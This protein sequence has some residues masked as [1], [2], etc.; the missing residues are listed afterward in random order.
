M[1]F[2]IHG[3]PMAPFAPLFELDDTALASMGATR[4]M[5]TSNPGFP[6]RVSLKDADVGEELILLNHRH[7][8]SNSPYAATHA[9]YVRKDARE[10]RPAPSEVPEVLSSRLL[11][12]RAFDAADMMQRA[13]V[14]EGDRLGDRL[15][16]ILAD[17]AIA[18]VHIHNAAPGCF[19]A[20]ATRAE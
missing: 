13:E 1:T 15:Q 14:V 11:S 5:A 12:L 20:S 3:L 6:C 8:P 7:L 19:A 10:A 18:Y 9:I 16:D 17:A 4:V 2:Q